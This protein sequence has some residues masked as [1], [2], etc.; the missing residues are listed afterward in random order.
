MLT[1][2]YYFLK[3]ILCSGILLLYYW[4]VLRNK[5]FHQ[6]NRFYL[7]IV[8]LFSWLIPLIKIQ[9]VQPA[10][11][12]QPQL[13]QLANIVADNNT[14]F[15][16]I[17]LQQGFAINWD[18]LAMTIYT[19]VSAFFLLSF[20][21]GITKVYQ[22]LKTN[23]CKTIGDVYLILTNA[24]GTPFSFFK[25][26]FWNEAIDIN[27]S[28]GKQMMQHEL[29]HVQEKHS[30]DKLFMQLVILFGWFN[31]FFWL[32][33]KELNM[34]HEFIADNKAI[35]NG[36]TASLATMLLTAAYPQQQYLLSNPFFFSPIKRRL[37][38]LTN[39]KNSKWS[40]ARRLVVLPL[41][42]TVVLLFA[43]R[44]K[45]V[46][47]NIPL[48][49]VYT[50]V[51]DAGHGGS[52]NGA[53]ALDG[54]TEKE[55]SLLMLKAIKSV[56]NND[57]IKLVFTRE[58]DVLQT[59]V[60][61]A[62]FVNAQ[63]ADLFVSLHM[64]FATKEEPVKNGIEVYVPRDN[65]RKNIEQCK[66]FATS[67]N[68]VLQQSFVSNGVKTRAA[69]VWVLKAT[70]CPAAL[71]ECGFISNAK[72]L[73]ILKNENQR[74]KMAEL[75]L[76][77][78]G[79]YLKTIENNQAASKQATSGLNSFQEKSN[80]TIPV[81]KSA[82]TVTLNGGKANKNIDTALKGNLKNSLIIV[83][84]QKLSYEA[85]KKIDPNDI[86]TINIYK[87]TD[88]NSANREN[89]KEDVIIVTTKKKSTESKS[90]DVIKEEKLPKDVLYIVDGKRITK[91]E[92]GKLNT[93]DLET[94]NVLKDK[95]AI[96]I[97]GEDGKN[98]VI[99]ITT[100]KKQAPISMVAPLN[101]SYVAEG[102]GK[103]L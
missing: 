73:A 66:L 65:D 74:K 26:I 17:V 80:D 24:K 23:S 70:E 58:T 88:N 81:N 35:E 11:A 46:D 49:K 91:E 37:A 22:L 51:I 54:T 69:G 77:G 50:V 63:K 92:M 90:T 59:P 41:L 75:I 10:E 18:L 102:F 85:F 76:T 31:P 32:A 4:M 36:D 101:N 86:A 2:A 16:K 53:A 64:N 84:E 39:T 43:F 52:D 29:I 67:I 83:D 30:A 94:V 3:V 42:A 33:K 82:I 87:Y 62:N 79:N 5:R 44:K 89:G 7:L 100:K 95:A 60:E 48:N 40:Y 47:N 13:I 68:Q 19:L 1:I 15:E 56:N 97:Y 99:I 93:S 61:K 34:I 6:Y 28:T 78:I 25:Y 98:G 8:G 96:A 14:E 45:E 9:F 21:A 38:M 103:Y 20:I 57:K 27:T 71:I 72:D 12:E 55:L